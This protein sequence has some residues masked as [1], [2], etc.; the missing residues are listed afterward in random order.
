MRIA[1]VGDVTIA[2]ATLPAAA[3][4]NLTLGS[5]LSVQRQ[6]GPA[7]PALQAEAAGST[8]PAP[9]G[10][11]PAA[12]VGVLKA[13]INFKFDQQSLEFALRDLQSLV[14][15]TVAG[16]VAFEIQVDGLSL[17]ADGITRNQQIGNFQ[18]DNKTVAQVLTQLVRQADPAL[19]SVE[20]EIPRPSGTLVWAAGPPLQ[21]EGSAQV[22]LITTVKVAQ[23]RGYRIPRDFRNR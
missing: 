4:H 23:Q 13:R 16:A 17:R 18:A 21:G 10:L 1:N 7:S 6:A 22:V 2:S 14:R 19:A 3:A 8:F 5:H 12:L 11:D 20:A 15:E 9:A